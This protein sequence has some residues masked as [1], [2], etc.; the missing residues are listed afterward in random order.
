VIVDRRFRDVYQQLF[1]FYQT[2]SE[3]PVAEGGA[4]LPP[5]SATLRQIINSVDTGFGERRGRLRADGKY[6]LLTNFY[7]MVFLPLFIGNR[8]DL[9]VGELLAAIESD[10]RDIVET[11]TASRPTREISGHV[12]MD[13]ASRRWPFLRTTRFRLWGDE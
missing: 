6:F 3:R 13:V 7:T 1:D 9:D 10:I 4:G 11:A 8:G 5:V 12:L 2:S